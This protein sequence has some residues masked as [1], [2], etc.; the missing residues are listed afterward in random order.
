MLRILLVSL[1]L[2]GPALAAG[3][4][5][6]FGVVHNTKEHSSITFDCNEIGVDG[7]ECS[8]VQVSV[9]KKGDPADLAKKVQEAREQFQKDPSGG[10][11]DKDCAGFSEMASALRG[12]K[13][14]GTPD[15][16]APLLC[17]KGA[18]D[19]IISRRIVAGQY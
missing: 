18:R 1:L 8:F 2:G 5:P 13:I 19:A 16:A 4:K 12:G 6:S 9:R 3:E 7:L 10:L 15:Q 14:A 17:R 11:K